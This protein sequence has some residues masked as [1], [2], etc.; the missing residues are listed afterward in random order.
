LTDKLEELYWAEA[1]A[2]RAYQRVEQG[3][4]LVSAQRV[5]PAKV[6]AARTEWLRALRAYTTAGG[7]YETTRDILAAHASTNAKRAR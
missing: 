2:Y 5:S 1:R 3:D 4:N 6:E 7:T